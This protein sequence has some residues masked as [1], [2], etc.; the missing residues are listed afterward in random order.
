MNKLKAIRTKAGLTQKK[1]AELSGVPLRVIK[2][3]EQEQRS[4]NNSQ[5]I[6]VIRLAVAL[7]CQILDLVE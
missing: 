5:A 7:E 6:T 1:L 4:I 2:S 3:Y